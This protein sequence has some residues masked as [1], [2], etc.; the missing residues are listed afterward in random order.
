MVWSYSSP[1]ASD[2]DAVRFLIGDTNTTQQ[3]LSNEEIAYILTIQSNVIRAAAF[4]AKTIAA[5]YSREV[6]SSIESV[7]VFAADKFKHYMEL[8]NSLLAE[9]ASSTSD[10]LGL[11]LIGGISISEIASVEEDTDRVKSAFKKGMW[12]NPPFVNEDDPYTN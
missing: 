4:A 7:R 10:G 6:G 2:T 5:K 3:Q 1:D 9:A 12:S 8:A 11:P